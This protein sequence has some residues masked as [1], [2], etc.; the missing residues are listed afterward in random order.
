MINDLSLRTVDSARWGTHFRR[1]LHGSYCFSGLP[2]SVRWL[3]GG[4]DTPG[5]PADVFGPLAREYDAVVLFFIDAFGWRFAAPAIERLPFLQRMVREG[6]LSKL[7]S[8]FPSTT[9]AHVT[10]I[11]T[12]LPVGQ[13]GVYAWTYYEPLLGTLISP[14]P[15]AYA[16]QGRNSL[17]HSGVAAADLLPRRTLYDDLAQQG[18]QSY[19]LGG[20]ESVGSPYSEVVY[21]GAE[22]VPY[23]S[24]PEALVNLTNLLQERRGKGYYYI[25]Q[26]RIDA[27]CH[28]YGPVAPQID[29]EIEALWWMI[30]HLFYA[31]VAGRLKNTLLLFTADHG[32]VPVDPGRII[33]L[34]HELPDIV[35]CVQTD[36]LGR[37]L[38]QAGSRRD[39]FLHVK[40]DYLPAV[41]ARIAEHV[42]GRAEVYLVADLIREGVFGQEAPATVFRERVGNLVVLPYV[43][44]AVWWADPLIPDK[45]HRGSHGGLTPEEMDIPLFV[46]SCD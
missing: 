36:R 31:R 40:E 39:H 21:R 26:D 1:P 16:G 18:I 33:Y 11:H 30:D 15:F 22:L 19:I 14:L 2:Q 4:A 34:N 45:Q 35:P 44:E 29:A 41:R 10:T 25:Y 3:L 12:G 37:P 20:P 24:I 17:R 5:L 8:Q 32:H 43:G 9:A 28:T 27:L 13:S 46:L 6:V 23:K 38:G 7:T 42:Q